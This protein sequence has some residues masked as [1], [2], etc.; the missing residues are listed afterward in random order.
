[1]AISNLGKVVIGTN[2]IVGTQFA[3]GKISKSL[4]PANKAAIESK[5]A[6]ANQQIV[7]AAEQTFKAY[8]PASYQALTAKQDKATISMKKAQE[9]KQSGPA[10]TQPSGKATKTQTDYVQ[11]STK[12]DINKGLQN[13]IPAYGILSTFFGQSAPFDIADRP[14]P[15]QDQMGNLLT[16]KDT[17]PYI[18][19]IVRE[20]PST[21]TVPQTGLEWIQQGNLTD[22]ILIGVVA[23]G[24]IWLLGTLLGRKK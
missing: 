11:E 24:G 13:L 2:P 20:Q 9:K 17:E 1:M 15:A 16:R 10:T 7:K 18:P 12:Y 4:A 23:L 14:V 3:L 5:L 19:V 6:P 22:K 21:Q 8:E